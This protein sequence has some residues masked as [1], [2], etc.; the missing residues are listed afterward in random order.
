MGDGDS[1]GVVGPL[2]FA[3]MFDCRTE[4]VG[5]IDPP[6][7]EEGCV[8][9]DFDEDGDVDQ[10]DHAAFQIVFERVSV[11]TVELVARLTPGTEDEVSELPVGDEEFS[12]GESFF[13]EIWARTNEVDGLASVYVDVLF[14]PAALNAEAITHTALFNLFQLGTIDNETGL[15]REVGGSHL[16][17]RGCEDPVGVAPGWGRVAVIE[18]RAEAAGASTVS[19]AGTDS[20]FTIS[21]CGTFEIPVGD[22]GDRELTIV[23]P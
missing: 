13:I 22:Y 17:A 19:S 16:G 1:D 11:V 3:L 18:M 20:P 2:D 12:V 14:D 15:I 7:Y 5:P 6:A 9:F 4:P 21:I 8:C 10:R 23:E